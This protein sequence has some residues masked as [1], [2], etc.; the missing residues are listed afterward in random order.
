MQPEAV[1]ETN[2]EIGV[3]LGGSSRAELLQA[4]PLGLFSSFSLLNNRIRE[5]FL[6]CFRLLLFLYHS[7]GFNAV[8]SA[9]QLSFKDSFNSNAN[10]GMH[11]C[12]ARF[13][14]E[15]PYQLRLHR[16]SS[17]PCEPSCTECVCCT[18]CAVQGQEPCW[19]MQRHKGRSHKLH[20]TSYGYGRV[21]S[22]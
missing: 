16:M 10:R 6:F 19:V 18:A 5:Q 17:C 22:R 8:I 9:A 21:A 1:Y 2:L 13:V 20:L 12:N 15:R 3:V 7:P 14:P 11:C 4:P